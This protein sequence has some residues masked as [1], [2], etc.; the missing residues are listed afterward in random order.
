MDITLPSTCHHGYLP[1]KRQLSASKLV[2]SLMAD[3]PSV[4]VMFSM[5]R[6]CDSKS[7]RSPPNVMSLIVFMLLLLCFPIVVI[8]LQKYKKTFNNRVSLFRIIIPLFLIMCA[9]YYCKGALSVSR[10]THKKAVSHVSLRVEH[11]KRMRPAVGL[12]PLNISLTNRCLR[13]IGL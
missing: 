1:K 12:H 2:H 9:H 7:G 8:C 10:Q 5:R 4:M 13:K 6:S 11:K 3:S